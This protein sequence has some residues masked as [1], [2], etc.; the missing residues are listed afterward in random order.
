MR[1]Y[2]SKY[3]SVLGR[4]SKQIPVMIICFVMNSFIE[5]I[6]LSLLFPLLYL[7]VDVDLFN[8]KF[9][10]LNSI[11][12]LSE[13]SFQY[14]LFIICSM[15]LIIY[16]FKSFFSYFI[17]RIIANFS[18]RSQAQ[19]IKEL[20]LG[21]QRLPYHKTIEIKESNFFNV[22]SN[23]V[24]QYTEMTLIGSLR[25]FSETLLIITIISY[26][27]YQDPLAVAL[28][29]I[30]FFL[31]AAS[32][33]FFM[34]N[35]FGIYGR[36]FSAATEN[37]LKSVREII[38]SFKEIKILGR[39][40]FFNKR[41]SDAS[42]D[43]GSYGGKAVAFTQMPKYIFE[44]AIITFMLVL[45]MYET[46]SRDNAAEGVVF[47]GIFAIA[48]ARMLP[49]TFQII[50]CLSWL[51]LSK[52][53]LEEIHEY[54]SLLNSEAY[55]VTYKSEKNMGFGE[56]F[57]KIEFKNL[58][59]T[60]KNGKNIFKDLNLTINQGDFVCIYGSSGSG[61]T[62]LVDL[63]LGL[64]EPDDDSNETGIFINSKKLSNNLDYWYTKVAYIPQKIFLINDSLIR[65]ISVTDDDDVKKELLMQSIKT[66]QLNDFIKNLKEGVDYNVGD[67][68]QKLSGGQRQRVVLARALYHERD[69]LVFDEATSSL[70]KQTE[71][72]IIEE[73][74]QLK[75][76]K[77][78]IFVTHNKDLL[79][80]ADFSI[81]VSEG[82]AT[83]IK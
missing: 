58:N 73:I 12:F 43:M 30:F 32:Y 63:I 70:D 77:T 39:E 48:A 31:I 40:K 78:I 67:D 28:L 57:S 6:G 35:F 64:L 33:F 61:K 83:V 79:K 4:R 62:T 36:K 74:Y 76:D 54:V 71:S 56:E 51:R 14:K 55:R 72:K 2:F 26:L 5:I 29:I 22:I 75:G 38:G 41:I 44:S 11:Y 23:H 17:I 47:I 13:I 16:Y 59:F 1:E 25:L 27:A 21:Y 45:V 66:S 8:E 9:E 68:G 20:I 18:Y 34:R 24:R 52:H 19:L 53:F 81:H 7:L 69:F 46:F 42:S 65:N 3:F 37:I 49:S 10:F 82:I 50:T 60:Y 15:I 80:Y